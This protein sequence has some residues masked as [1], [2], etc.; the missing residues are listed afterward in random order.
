MEQQPL[1]P[2]FKKLKP[3]IIGKNLKTLQDILLWTSDK[4]QKLEKEIN[5]YKGANEIIGDLLTQHR[6]EKLLKATY[7][8]FSVEP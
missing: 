2:T 7:N 8:I 6:K 4:I 3:Y 5:S 1:P